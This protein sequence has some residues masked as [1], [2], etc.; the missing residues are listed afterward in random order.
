MAFRG[1]ADDGPLIVVFG[2]SHPSSTN[3]NVVKV[4]PPLNF[5]SGSAHE[6][7][8]SVTKV[9]REFNSRLLITFANSLDPDLA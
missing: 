9:D 6:R 4:G 5:F 3:K 7:H 2:S 8:R 1:R